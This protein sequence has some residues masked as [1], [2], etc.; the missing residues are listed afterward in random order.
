[1]NYKNKI[2]GLVVLSLFASLITNLNK[3]FKVAKA[4][5]NKTVL[6]F[7]NENDLNYFEA[8]T[9]L[10]GEVANIVN[11][12]V[13]SCWKI[14][15]GKL[16]SLKDSGYNTLLFKGLGL[17]NYVIEA[18]V[19]IPDDG[20]VGFYTNGRYK[21]VKMMKG[22]SNNESDVYVDYAGGAFIKKD[23]ETTLC[24]CYKAICGYENTSIPSFDYLTSHHL[25]MESY[26]GS[27]TLYVDGNKVLERSGRQATGYIGLQTFN[28][29]ATYDNVSVIKL[30]QN[31]NEVD[32]LNN[33]RKTVACIGDSLTYFSGADATDGMALY[34]TNQSIVGM[35]NEKLGDNFEVYNFGNGGKGVLETGGIAI[36]G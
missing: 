18:D 7:E 5:N 28:S 34:R 10:T 25:K 11:E 23:G 16:V 22:Y 1:M 21:G 36:T 20:Y 2:I 26:D 6:S 27:Y 17:M 3:D 15:D 35:L 14:E 8:F 9:N 33:T 32:V 19:S 29:K 4:D 31:K 12:E 24:G 13:S 30:D